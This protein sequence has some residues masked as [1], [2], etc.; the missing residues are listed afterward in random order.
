[1]SAVKSV[2]PSFCLSVRM[3]QFDSHWMDFFEISYLS[4]FQNYDED[5]QVSLK[6]DR[7]NG[8]FTWRSIY[9]Y[10]NIS[11]RFS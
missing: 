8:Y 1:M 9:I 7:N 2:C 4:I 10:D 3:E 6:P 5:I 11:L